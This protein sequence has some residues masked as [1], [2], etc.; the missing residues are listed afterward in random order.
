MGSR[1]EALATEFEQAAAEFATAIEA[2]SDAHWRT[3]C[4]AEGWTVAQTAQHLSGGFRSR[5]NM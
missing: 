1:S 2:C 3:V 5:W 4:N